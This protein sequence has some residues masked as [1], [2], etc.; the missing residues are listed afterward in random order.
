M[1]E[2]RKRPSSARESSQ[3]KRSSTT[4]TE[5][6]SPPRKQSISLEVPTTFARDGPLPVL[7]E[8]QP[9]KL[10][11]KDYKSVAESKVMA[12][13]L[14]RSQR[15]WVD[16]DI[17]EKYWIK[18]LKSRKLE[19]ADLEKNPHKDTM[20]RLGHCTLSCLPH[21]FEIKLFGVLE[22]V[23][24]PAPPPSPAAHQAP[25]QQPQSWQRPPQPPATTT[26]SHSRTPNTVQPQ[27]PHPYP[28]ALVPPSQT[29]VPQHATANLALPTPSPA[30]ASAPAMPA[31]SPAATQYQ[32]PR[33]PVVGAPAPVPQNSVP[34]SPAPNPNP[35]PPNAI[36]RPVQAPQNVHPNQPRPPPPPAPRPDPVIQMLA[37]RAAS[38]P[39][40]KALMRIVASGKATTEQLRIFQGHIDS[41]TP[42]HSPS[43]IPT[44]GTARPM[45]HAPMPNGTPMAG[46]RP[47][48]PQPN[49]GYPRQQHV[50]QHPQHLPRPVLYPPPPPPP[51][52]VSQYQP[53]QPVQ[54]PKPKPFPQPPKQEVTSVV[55]EFVDIYSQGDRFIF[56]KHTIL[57]YCNGGTMVKASFIVIRKPIDDL[58]EYFQPITVILESPN[59]K[60]LDVFQ[61]VV[62]DQ[63]TT[64]KYMTELMKTRKR[65]DDSY[66]AFRL[67]RVS[68]EE[69]LENELYEQ[70]LERPT[71]TAAKESK[72]RRESIAPILESKAAEGTPQPAYSGPRIKNVKKAITRDP[73]AS[74]KASSSSTTPIAPSPK[75]PRPYKPPR[76]RR[77]RIADPTK[78]CHICNTSKT[79][80]WR[81]ADIEGE[82]VTVC[83]ACGIK[84]KTNAQKA[85]Q[86]A[87]AAASG[88]PF[89]EKKRGSSA[90]NMPRPTIQQLVIGGPQMQYNPFSAAPGYSKLLP[91]VSLP[92]LSGQDSVAAETPIIAQQQP[93]FVLPFSSQRT[94]VA[95]Q[96]Q[97]AVE[98]PLSAAPVPSQSSS[99]QIPPVSSSQ[100]PQSGPVEDAL[101]NLA[102]TAE[103]PSA[104]GPSVMPSNEA[105]PTGT[106]VAS[107]QVDAPSPRAQEAPVAP[108]Q[109]QNS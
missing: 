109:P 8:R 78:S 23:K 42:A 59:T 57:E 102:S 33:P 106:T 90:S 74:P 46:P 71:R 70:K 92:S 26:Q 49:V 79:S 54:A 39:D 72:A 10:S 65:A 100:P 107:A 58:D 1:G 99:P 82:S 61:K 5:A 15:K 12:E 56:P 64:R 94:T 75:T 18:P 108:P 4:P 93:G 34:Q 98:R 55:F 20:V 67:K 44:I 69:T 76:S 2:K 104:V 85:A 84:W 77:G 7:P 87:A 45:A 52:P 105:Q 41:L 89:P 37:F 62:A 9:Q 83:N 32:P 29:T 3:L 19:T 6:A 48:Q 96:P 80:L 13:S 73:D 95:P 47:S 14:L 51:T 101:P 28:A 53:P 11:S 68:N 21:K 63:E 50:Q 88:Q 38:D 30:A 25:P 27:P 60:T 97:P 103:N 35:P 91:P 36:P 86:M 40:L 66:L 24:A 17:F 81:K 43:I 16:G 31:P 22:P